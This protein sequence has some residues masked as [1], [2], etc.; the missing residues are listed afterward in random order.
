MDALQIVVLVAALASLVCW[1]LSL[2]TRDTSWVDRAWSIVPVVYVWI[3][4]V[5]AFTADA[6]SARIVLM[7]ILAT[8]WGARLTF[9]FARKGGYTGME[10]YR[11]AILRK[12]MR[13]WQFQVFNLL[14]IIG[15]QMTLLVLIT[16]PAWLA[17]QHPTALTGWDALF[18][19][20]FLGFLVGE[21]VADQQQW[22][23]HQRKKQAGGDLAPGFAT[24]GLFRYSRHPNFFFE[25]AQWWAFYALGATAAATAGAGVLG[26]VL[27]P[28][29]VGA[30]LL[31]VLFLGSTI[32][33]ESITASKYPAYADYRQTTS[34]LVPWPPRR[35]AVAPQS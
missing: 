17:A 12:R 35:R 19:I 31:T 10:D 5:G 20:A 3:F 7:G 24:T 27:N 11:W 26:G 18:T 4:V 28:T 16:L 8:A 21:T 13:P 32:F 25:Q 14:F 29:I 34:M 2:I 30:A 33:T 15:Y 6:G 23:F 1:I 9:N 22:N